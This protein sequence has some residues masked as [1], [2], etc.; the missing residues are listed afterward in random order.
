MS[1]HACIDNSC[2]AGTRKIHLRNSKLHLP[3]PALSRVLSP[4]PIFRRCP[5][6]APPKP[7]NTHFVRKTDL[8]PRKTHGDSTCVITIYHNAICTTVQCEPC[9]AFKTILAS[10]KSCS[11]P[12]TLD[13][14]K[15]TWWLTVAKECRPWTTSNAPPPKTMANPWGKGVKRVL[16]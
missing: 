14:S 7:R 15:A 13:V 1:F 2:Q 10:N 16:E 9:N 6:T 5:E 8:Q 12:R 3:W 11:I 4:E